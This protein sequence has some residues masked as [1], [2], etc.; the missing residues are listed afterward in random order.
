FYLAPLTAHLNLYRSQ[1]T[2]D[3]SFLS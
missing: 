2:T 3:A 1:N